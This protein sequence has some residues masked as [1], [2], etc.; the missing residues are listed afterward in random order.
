MTLYRATF[1]TK[2]GV[3]RRMTFSVSGGHRA[4]WQFAESWELRDDNLQ[5]VAAIR[6]IA[7][8]EFQLQSN[9]SGV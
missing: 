6:P 7:R 8:P 9:L 1:A 4:A 3:H 5:S 2:A